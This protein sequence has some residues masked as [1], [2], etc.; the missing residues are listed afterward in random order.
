MELSVL[1]ITVMCDEAVVKDTKYIHVLL[2][3]ISNII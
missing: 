2:G 1:D 3:K